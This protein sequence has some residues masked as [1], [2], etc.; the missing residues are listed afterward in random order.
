VDNDFA[1]G[2]SNVTNQWE[3]LRQQ[4]AATKSCE[5]CKSLRIL[6]R[7]LKRRKTELSIKASELREPVE[8]CDLCRIFYQC[9]KRYEKW[10]QEMI[11][12][13]AWEDMGEEEMVEVFRN[14]SIVT[15]GFHGIPV[16]TIY[17]DPG[18]WTLYYPLINNT[19][20]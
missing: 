2:L 1:L 8:S 5:D 12:D 19:R 7:L 3:T 10:Y 14:G 6:S 9:F 16:L 17:T 20:S 4:P 18:L 13:M 15:M 11:K